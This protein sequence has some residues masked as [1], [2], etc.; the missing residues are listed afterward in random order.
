MYYKEL[1]LQDTTRELLQAKIEQFRVQNNSD[2]V[3]VKTQRRVFKFLD[4]N[5]A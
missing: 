2:A 5:V 4:K 1:S 3:V